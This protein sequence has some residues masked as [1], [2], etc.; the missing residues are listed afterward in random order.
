MYINVRFRVSFS[1]ASWQNSDF[2]C[3][4]E[5]HSKMAGYLPIFYI[6]NY[7]PVFPHPVTLEWNI[8]K[9]KHPD[10]YVQTTQGILEFWKLP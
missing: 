3:S 2:P 5:M 10:A 8:Y 9:I 4:R 7:T 1:E 6:A